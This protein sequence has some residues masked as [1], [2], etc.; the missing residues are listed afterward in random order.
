MNKL[1]KEADLCF[2]VFMEKGENL[3]KE[4]GECDEADNIKETI[5]DILQNYQSFVKEFN[6]MN[7]NFSL[8]KIKI[9]LDN[10]NQGTFERFDEFSHSTL[11]LKEPVDE[12]ETP[13]SFVSAAKL[14]PS[15]QLLHS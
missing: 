3:L 12:I 6:S 15:C 5:E 10:Q 9:A 4:K 13:E 7:S 1:E 14:N 8:K 2:Q 11:N